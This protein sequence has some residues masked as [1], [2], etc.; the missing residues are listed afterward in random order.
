[1]NGLL[2]YWIALTVLF[3]EIREL[4]EDKVGLPII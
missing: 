4:P 3:A 1:M 2:H